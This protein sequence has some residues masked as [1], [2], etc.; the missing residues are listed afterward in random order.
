MMR[1]GFDEQLEQLN[2]RLIKMGALFESSIA[3][4]A[5]ALLDGDLALARRVAALDLEIDNA[6]R[7]IEAFC[8]KLLL[9]QQPVARDLRS[10]SAALKMIT[11]MERIGDQSE[12]IAEIVTMAQ[13]T[14]SD[15]T[16]HI[17]EM[18]RAAI[19][20]V[21]DSVEAFVKR[22]VALARQVVS[23]DDI[24]DGL[25]DEVKSAIANRFRNSDS[26][27]CALDLLMIAKYFER[28]GDHAVNIAQ[29]VLYAVTGEKE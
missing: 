9:R 17:G 19:G 27:T 13:L 28:I 26:L 10:I 29:W 16:L 24:V 25:F 2:T 12:D 7:D 1:T 3:M 8:M 11:D 18:A 14:A 6:Q 22:D 23:D 15:E 5:K 4:A 20:M 21:T